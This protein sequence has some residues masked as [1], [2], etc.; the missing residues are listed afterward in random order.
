MARVGS[1]I[2]ASSL[3]SLR[4]VQLRSAQAGP[5]FRAPQQGGPA[6]SFLA[7]NPKVLRVPS[8]KHETNPEP[9]KPYLPCKPCE[10]HKP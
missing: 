10:P 4:N 9:K 2:K 8:S 3:G 1:K 6:T 5:Q 7:L